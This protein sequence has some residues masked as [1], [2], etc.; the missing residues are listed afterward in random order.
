M[1]L[2][3]TQPQVELEA[4]AE[5]GKKVSQSNAKTNGISIMRFQCGTAQSSLYSLLLATIIYKS[6]NRG[7]VEWSYL[8]FI[9]LFR[10]ERLAC[11]VTELS[12]HY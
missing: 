3:L 11:A 12:V 7:S 2:R 6:I 4:C 8:I 9:C 5:L 10:S 1:N